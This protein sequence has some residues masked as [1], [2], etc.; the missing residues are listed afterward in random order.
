MQQNLWGISVVKSASYYVFHDESIPNKRWLLIGLLF[1]AEEDLERTREFLSCLR[2]KEN[3]YGEIHFSKLPRS[4]DGAFGSKARLAR[5]WLCEFE[6][7]LA[8]KARFTALVVDRQSPAYNPARF[9]REFHAYNRFTA[10]ALKAGVSFFL[11]KT[12]RKKYQSL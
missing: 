4:F 10:M 9:S 3:Y 1:V 6:R 2:Q 11:L 5:S 12:I 7:Y 8:D